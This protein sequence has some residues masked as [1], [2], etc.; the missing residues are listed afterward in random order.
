[1]SDHQPNV[2]SSHSGAAPAADPTWE[3]LEDQIKWYDSKS[4]QSQRAYKQVKVLQLVVAAS[5]PVAAVLEPPAAVTA[6]LGAVVLI[7]EAVQQLFQWQTTWVQYRS[8]AEAL[9][10]ERYLFLAH[11]GPYVERGRHRVLAEQIEGLV[12]QEHAKWIQAR[13]GPTDKTAGDHG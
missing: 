8:T 10:H 6:G 7:L 13:H 11:A 9:K 2:E 4:S 3:R 5:L 1:M 12:S